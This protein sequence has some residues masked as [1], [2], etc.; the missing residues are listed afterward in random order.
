MNTCQHVLARDFVVMV[1]GKWRLAEIVH[2]I[3]FRGYGHRMSSTSLEGRYE[4]PRDV[5]ANVSS[6]TFPIAPV[7]NFIEGLVKS[8]SVVVSSMDRRLSTRRE[9]ITDVISWVNCAPTALRSSTASYNILNNVQS[10]FV[11]CTYE[12][13]ECIQQICHENDE[14]VHSTISNEEVKR[15]GM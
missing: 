1:S 15:S 10:E 13:D 8:P 11:S 9:I 5:S 7:T 2:I 12:E 14:K 6:S 4:D 3:R